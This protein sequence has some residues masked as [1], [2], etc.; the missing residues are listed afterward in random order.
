MITAR[1]LQCRGAEIMLR[2]ARAF[3]TMARASLSALVRRARYN[4]ESCP[5]RRFPQDGRRCVECGNGKLVIQWLQSRIE[6]LAN[7]KQR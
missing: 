4:L 2:F 5:C 1:D 7:E 6:E 3:P